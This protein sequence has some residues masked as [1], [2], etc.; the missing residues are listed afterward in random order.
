M[1]V[2]PAAKGWVKWS[3]MYKLCG[4]VIGANGS[5]Q[6]ILGREIAKWCTLIV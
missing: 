6:M 4:A 1:R 2:W 5:E 3:S